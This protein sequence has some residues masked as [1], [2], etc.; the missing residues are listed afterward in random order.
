MN[1]KLVWNREPAAWVAL[2]VAAFGAVTALGFDVSTTFQ[3]VSVAV[4]SAVLALVVAIQ[5]HDGVIAAVMGLSQSL[6]SLV[7][8]LGYHL[9]ADNQYK[10][11]LFVAAAVAWYTRKNVTAPA[12]ASVSPSGT[13]ASSKGLRSVQ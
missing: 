8:G 12:P 5:T 6:V 9:T 3:S 2:I 4:V 7:V 11:M 1:L 10:I 13:L